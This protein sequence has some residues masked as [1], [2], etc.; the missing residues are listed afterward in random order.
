MSKVEFLRWLTSLG[1]YDENLPYHNT[2]DPIRG[3]WCY[4]DDYEG[5]RIVIYNSEMTSSIAVYLNEDFE[6]NVHLCIPEVHH[7]LGI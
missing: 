2:C 7:L 1:I 4:R 3:Y 6:Q 5:E